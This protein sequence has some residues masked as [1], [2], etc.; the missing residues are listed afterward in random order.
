[1]NGIPGIEFKKDKFPIIDSNG[2]SYEL[3]FY[4]NSTYFANIDNFVSFIKGT[5]KLIRT[6]TF[7]SAYIKY[8]KKDIGL[9]R[10]QVL[11]NITDDDNVDIEMHHGPILTL[12]DY[13][14]IIIDYLMV[15]NRKVNS[16]I[17]ADIVLEE[18]FN[19]LVQV[20]MLSKTVH[21]QASPNKI[22]INLRQAFGDLNGFIKKYKKGLQKE[23]IIK[24]N[25][26]IRLSEENNSNDR[27]ILELK[28]NIKRWGKTSE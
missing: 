19:N 9:D 13:V 18:H 7:Y 16:F 14:A 10:C 4:K 3:P 1:M 22:F 8:L 27:N 17:V 15:T 21:Q 28:E 20:V 26:Y 5:E 11:S 6:S 25:E 2:A 24:I 12:F 23:H